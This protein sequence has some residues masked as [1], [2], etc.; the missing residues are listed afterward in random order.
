MARIRTIKP[1][2]FRHEGLYEAEQETGLPLRVAFA[3][4]WTACDREGRFEWRPK[5]LKLDC[6]PYDQTDF[7]RVLDALA[8]RGFVVKYASG[9]DEYGYIPS[10]RRH[11][12]INN[13]ESASTIPKPSEIKE[14]PTRAARVSDASSTRECNYQ[15]EG[16]GKGKGREEHHTVDLETAPGST[17]CGVVP[18]DGGEATPTPTPPPDPAVYAA[19]DALRVTLVS[20]TA[21]HEAAGALWGVL[22]ANSCTGTA[23]HP[24]VVEMARSGVTAADLRKAIA[25][26]RKTQEGPLNPAYL[27][28]IVDRLKT[29][30]PKA[31]GKGAAW[32][33]DEK[34]TEAKARELG[35]WP[36][37]GG[38]SW[39]G[40]R[41]RIRAR[42]NTAAEESVR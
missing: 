3:G 27:A 18:P 2:F 41:N 17:P 12:V 42:L 6:L 1:D 33:T 30:P 9:T 23:S 31:N 26:A 10:W 20:G 39:D 28:S 32:A 34:A 15:G 21:E 8:T 25:E 24:A 22:S 11:Q 13:R 37:R 5:Q 4:L 19:V 35:L 7:S 29:A 38:E 40:L 36:A 14:L 16:E